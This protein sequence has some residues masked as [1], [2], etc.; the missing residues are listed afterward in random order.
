M[1]TDFLNALRQVQ[2]SNSGSSTNYGSQS[3]P[4]VELYGGG[5]KTGKYLGNLY[6]AYNDARQKRGDGTIEY[7]AF[8]D[9]INDFIGQMGVAEGKWSEDEYKN[10]SYNQNAFNAYANALTPALFGYDANAEKPWD[11]FKDYTD[12]MDDETKAAFNRISSNAIEPNW[13]SE[14]LKKR[15]DERF[16]DDT[17]VG[18]Y[19]MDFFG[20]AGDYIGSGAA[21]IWNSPYT[22]GDNYKKDLEKVSKYA[23]SRDMATA[24]ILDN[25]QDYIA[26]ARDAQKMSSESG[27]GS[28]SGSTGSTSGSSFS[29]NVSEGDYVT[30]TYKPGDTFGQKIVD[31]G[32]A[33]KNGLWGTDGDVNFYTRQLIEQGALDDN[34]NVKLGQTFKLRRRK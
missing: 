28:G 25:Y 9:K 20:T 31:L 34:G 22:Y 2:Q 21:A 16:S 1:N 27:S 26:K 18:D 6:N 11:A 4:N 5:E 23:Q 7:D 17:N 29:D 32:L 24:D 33:T 3:T 30:F 19:V 10:K 12:A 8:V 13:S 15:T 14:A